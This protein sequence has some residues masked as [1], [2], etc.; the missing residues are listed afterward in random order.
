MKAFYPKSTE[1]IIHKGKTGNIYKLDGIQKCESLRNKLKEDTKFEVIDILITTPE[2]KQVTI[3]LINKVHDPKILESYITGTPRELAEKSGLMWQTDLYS[4]AMES[5]L[6]SKLSTEEA[7]KSGKALA[8]VG[9]G[10]HAEY[11]KPLG[12]CVINTMAIAAQYALNENKKVVILD[13]DTHYS[14]GCFD[15]LKNKE[16]VKVYSLWNQKIDKWKYYESQE[17]IW[18]AQTK[19]INS[20]FKELNNALQKIK[21]YKPD[22]FIYHL[23]LDVLE[24]DRMGGVHEMTIEKLLEREKI[25]RNFLQEEKIPYVIFMGGAY[26]DWSKGNEY[27]IHQREYLT[28]IQHN[29]LQE[30]N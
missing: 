20:Y 12:F 1:K 9:G 24:T 14:N 17:N 5:G 29:I 25:V 15:T 6:V 23:G 28:N 21:E 3:D 2:E 10:H 27:G 16:N 11:S 8:I 7:L 26:I 19:D 30:L 4:Y 22:I 13:L 18:H